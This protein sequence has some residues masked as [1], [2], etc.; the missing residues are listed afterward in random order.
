M[1]D[2]LKRIEEAAMKD[3]DKKDSLGGTYKPIEK[4]QSA[5]PS[6]G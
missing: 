3:F 2:E 4:M 1:Q 5:I 6:K